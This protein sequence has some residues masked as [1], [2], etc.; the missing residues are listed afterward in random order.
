MD[1]LLVY[2]VIVALVPAVIGINVFLRN[3][4]IKSSESQ[5]CEAY[6]DPA[7]YSGDRPDSPFWKS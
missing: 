3:R 1:D 4:R 7:Y 6:S 5:K 2:I